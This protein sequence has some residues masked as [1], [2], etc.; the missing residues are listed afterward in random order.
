MRVR[1]KVMA[2]ETVKE[3]AKEPGLVAHSEQK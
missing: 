1:E 2:K 3:M